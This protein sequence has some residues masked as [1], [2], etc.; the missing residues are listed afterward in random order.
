MVLDNLFIYFYQK[1]PSSYYFS[2]CLILMLWC[3][4]SCATLFEFLFCSGDHLVSIESSAIQLMIW[5]SILQ[6]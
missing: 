6:I 1:L 3:I 4:S 5:A 2:L